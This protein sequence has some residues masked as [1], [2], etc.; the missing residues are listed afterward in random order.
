MYNPESGDSSGYYEW[1]TVEDAENYSRSFAAGFM[2]RR[3]VPGSVSFNVLP[4]EASPRN[5]I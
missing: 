4:Q 5:G 3:S 1:D 2:A